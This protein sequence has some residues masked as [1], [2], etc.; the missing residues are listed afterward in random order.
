MIHDLNSVWKK[1]AKSQ[2]LSFDDN[3]NTNII[4]DDIFNL[5]KTF[6]KALQYIKCQLCICKVYRLTLS[7]R[8]VIFFKKD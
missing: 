6:A 5:A 3:T 2:G 7:L 1:V 4:V 8:K